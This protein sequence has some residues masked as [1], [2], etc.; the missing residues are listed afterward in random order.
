MMSRY[1]PKMPNGNSRPRYYGR[2][3]PVH[4]DAIQN[5][6]PD[7][8]SAM[9]DRNQIREGV[10]QC[11]GNNPTAMGDVGEGKVPDV[12]GIEPASA[13]AGE[14]S[15][16]TGARKGIVGFG[17]RLLDDT[18]RVEVESKLLQVSAIHGENDETCKRNLRGPGVTWMAP[19]SEEGEIW[20]GEG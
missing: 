4:G 10:E 7:R 17:Q 6:L 3:H 1:T 16:F 14:Q 19:E 5:V 11:C 8:P 20:H 2:N 12:Q 13:G 18:G 15:R 9:L